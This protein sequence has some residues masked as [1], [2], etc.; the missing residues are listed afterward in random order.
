MV[1]AELPHVNVLSKID[2]IR[3]IKPDVLI[4]G[5]D[6]T[7]DNVVGA[8]VVLANGGTVLLAELVP[9][10]SSTNT[11]AKARRRG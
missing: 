2:L 4:K 6:Y 9:G 10:V 1:C 11:I 3:A 7:L 8:D 5:A